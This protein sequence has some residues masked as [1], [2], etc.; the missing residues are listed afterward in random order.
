MAYNDRGVAIRDGTTKPLG[1]RKTVGRSA[2]E[3][4]E[5]HSAGKPGGYNLMKISP[6]SPNL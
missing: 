4:N 5:C 2:F 1:C 6:G 3:A